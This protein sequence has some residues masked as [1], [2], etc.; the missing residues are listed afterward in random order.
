MLVLENRVAIVVP[1]EWWYVGE[2]FEKVFAMGLHREGAIVSPDQRARAADDGGE[3]VDAVD[4]EDRMRTLRGRRGGR[5]L[6]V[7]NGEIVRLAAGRAVP[8]STRVRIESGSAAFGVVE[9]SRLNFGEP[10]L[11]LST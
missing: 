10:A 8:E 6:L 11:L 9:V 7:A 2:P 5:V 1:E 3:L 4:V